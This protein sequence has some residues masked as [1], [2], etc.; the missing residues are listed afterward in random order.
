MMRNSSVWVLLLAV[1]CYAQA[2]SAQRRP[3][4]PKGVSMNH[5]QKNPA[6]ELLRLADDEYFALSEERRVH[7]ADAFSEISN[8]D[9]AHDPAAIP[10]RL[11]L[12]APLRVDMKSRSRVPVLLGSFETGLRGWRINF[13][14]NLNIFVKSRSTGALLHSTP[15]ISVRRGLEQAPSGAGNPP[16]GAQAA[17]TRTGV[18]LVDLSDRMADKL[19]SGEI[20]ATAVAFD[21]HSNTVRIRL[22]GSEKP[23]TAAAAKESYV[24]YELDKRPSIDEK[25]VV[26]SSG[27]AKNGFRIQVV[28]QLVEEDGVLRTEENQPFL[29]SH[30]VLVRLDQPAVVI[31]ASPLVQ[32]VALPDGKQVFN[33]LFLVEIGGEKGHAVVPGDYQVYLD[34]G[35]SFLGP[36]P[37]KVG[38]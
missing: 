8:D 9:D 10:P 3:A 6:A 20:F 16:V 2:P 29:P 27:S 1:A 38:E 33:A 12:G 22:D 18:V 26:P 13:K 36:Y 32:Q 19:A 25:I 15:L 30:V 5:E 24:R 34:L 21:V 23:R 35:A 14:R 7:L 28:E 11:A 17:V 37:L 4:L 31:Q